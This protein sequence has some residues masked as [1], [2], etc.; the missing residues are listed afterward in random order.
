[1]HATFIF[2]FLCVFLFLFLLTEMKLTLYR[3][4]PHDMVDKT[5]LDIQTIWLI[6]LKIDI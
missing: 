1:M 2:I 6:E 3:Y 5:D 4:D